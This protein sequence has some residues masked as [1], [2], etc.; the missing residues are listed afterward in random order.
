MSIPIDRLYHFI[1]QH[2][3]K[4][5]GGRVIIYRFF[6][7]GE[8]NINNLLQ[9]SPITDMEWVTSP[10]IICNDQEPLVF[11]MYEN[12]DPLFNNMRVDHYTIWDN[13]ILLHSE[14]NS[15]EVQKYVNSG[16]T[17]VYYWS[18]ALIARDWF[19]YAEYVPL[20]TK[21]TNSKFLIYNRAWSGTRE[22]RLKFVDMLIDSGLIPYC[23]VKQNP[24][25]PTIGIHYKD[26]T[27]VNDK[28]KPNNIS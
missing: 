16:F 22:Y 25:D 1:E 7:H 15:S 10:E 21:E 13:S 17:P 11:N 3:Q 23:N 12:P 6:P 9:L 26:H 27:F 4:I 5:Q 2:A 28:M 20:S 8:K 19:R 18:H 14:K 24:I